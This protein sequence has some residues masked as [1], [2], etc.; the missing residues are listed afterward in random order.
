VNIHD[1][2]AANLLVLFSPEADYQVFNVGGGKAY[3]VS[4]FAAIVADVYG[5]DSS[6]RVPG[7][8]RFGDTRHIMSDI[9]KLKGLGWSPTRTPKDSVTEYVEW[10]RAQKRV[11]DILEYVE[12]HMKKLNVVRQVNG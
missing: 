6:P 5:K 1:V 2:V 11:E 7:S 12:N 4:E 9:S 10:L 8:Y 3:S